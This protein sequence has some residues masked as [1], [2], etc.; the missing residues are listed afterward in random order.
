MLILRS[1][2]GAALFSSPALGDRTITDA[3]YLDKL[4]GMWLGQ[5]IGNHTGRPFEGSYCT[6]EAVPDSAFAWVIKTSYEDPWTGDDDTSFEY[7]DLHCLETHGLDPSYAQ[8]QS[9]WDAHVTLNGIYIANLQAKFL[10]NGGFLAPATGSY[11]SNM[12]AYAIDSQITTESLGAMGPGMR[13][14]AIDSA[15]KFGGVTNEGF[16][17]HAA[18]FYAATYAAAAFE[19]NVETI[20]ALGQASIPNSSRTWQA[21][22]DVR[23][24]Y[25][26]DMADDVPDWRETRRKI[27]DYY[28]GAY[29]HGRYRFWIES[30]INVANTVLALL[31][32]QGDFEETV[33]IAVLSGYDAD[34]NPATAG[35]LIGMIRGYDALPADLTGPATDYYKVLYRPGLPQYDTI[36]DIAARMR[37]IGEQVMVANGGTVGGGVCTLPDADQVTP[38]PEMPD[39]PGPTGLVAAVRSEGGTVSVSASIAKHNPLEDRDNLESII[40]GITNVRY[41]GHV[42]YDTYDGDNPQPAGGDFYQI[43]FSRFVRFDSLT[44]YEGDIRWNGPNSDPRVSE[45][46]GGYFLNLMVEVHTAQGWVTAQNLELS[47]PLDPYAYYQAIDLTFD[48]VVGD[49]VRIRGDAGGSRQYT[50]IVELVCRGALTGDFDGNDVVDYADLGVFVDVLLGLETNPVLILTADLNGDGAS[51]GRDIQPFVAP[52]LEP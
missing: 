39:P 42:P 26:A 45:P 4:R 24:W 51:D 18:E 19:S 12:H 25:V 37:G 8:I 48:P 49:G 46:Y 44:F 2:L 41:N 22:Q 20:V 43:T 14:W 15:R 31:Y 47:E 40:D 23:N 33:R 35:G 11:R 1:A 52:L 6:R 16:S 38:D 5:L 34:C 9:E 3:A 30:T 29:D 28:N 7:L 27:Y 13:Q 21:I 50:S 32:G 10:M 36:T 17:L